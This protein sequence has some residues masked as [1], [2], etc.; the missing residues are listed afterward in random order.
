MEGREDIV[1]FAADEAEETVSTLYKKAG[2]WF[3]DIISN[4]YLDKIRD[5]WLA[6]HGATYDDSGHK[7]N[8][9]GEQGELVNLRVNHYRNIAQHILNMVTSTRPAFQARS[10]NTDYKSLVQTKLANGLLDYY[11]REK[12]MERYLKTAVEYAV[13]FGTGYIKMGWNATSG[14]MV[15]FNEELETPIY[16]GDVEFSNLSPYDVV[17]DSTKE[18]PKYD[19]I[20]CRTF[21]NK[22]DIAAKYPELKDKILGLKSKSDLNRQMMVGKAYDETVDVPV[23]EFFHN[24]TE[25]MED[26]RYLLYLEDDIVLL[27]SP[28]PYREIPVYRIS[29]SEILGTPYG[30]TSMFDLLPMQEAINMLYSTALTNQNAFGVQN[31]Y[32]PKGA[33]I[34]LN[35]FSSGLNVIEGNPQFGK[36]ESLQL[37]ST[38]AEIFN[39]MQQLVHD[40]ETISGVNSV[41]RGNPEA[42]LKSGNAL[43]LIQ[44]QA[45]QFISGLQQMYIQTIEDS[46]TGLI[47]LLKDFASAPRIAAIVGKGNRT[48]MKEF[49]GEDLDSINRVIVDVGNALSTTTAGRVQ[50]ADNLLQ[51]GAIQSADE[52]LAVMNS[53]KLETMT[54]GKNNE[55]MLIKSENERLVDGTTGIMAVATDNHAF[56][57]KEHQYVMLTQI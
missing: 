46:G 7:L 21:K 25:S 31:I 14:E 1:Y 3:D 18:G 52:Y 48:E 19:W 50:M 34:S 6:Y 16:A 32:V 51:M 41:A 10:T 33:D 8:F 49:V 23:F 40:M 42:S 11:M 35:Q 36:P 44:S 22:F 30:Y 4:G 55:I 20:I 15:D 39:F 45:L 13:V 54:E 56:H 2:D 17:F 43:A 5:S 27:D 12:R 26:G 53:G 29:P 57:I 47:N 37:T 24:R 28:L 9:S 38:P